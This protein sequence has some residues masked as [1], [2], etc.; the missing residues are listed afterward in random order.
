MA[1]SILRYSGYALRY[2]NFSEREGNMQKVSAGTAIILLIMHEKK[3][4]NDDTFRAI[5]K[6]YGIN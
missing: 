5:C 4:I 2:C 1:K 6:K 3:L